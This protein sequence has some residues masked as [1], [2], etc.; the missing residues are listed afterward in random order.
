MKKSCILNLVVIIILCFTGTAFSDSWRNG[1][2]KRGHDKQQYSQRHQDRRDRSDR[3]DYREDTDR[4]ETYSRRDHGN[5]ADFH[6]YHGYR[7]L[8]YGKSRHY[9]HHD[10]RGHRYAYQGHW[11][12]WEQW[13]RYA[14]VH[15]EIY[16]HGDYYREGAHLMFRFLDPVSG[17]YFFFSIGR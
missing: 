16:R 11:K 2:G 17:G 12:S 13:D 7:E 6:K 4:R 1:S 3:R 14:K 15:P 10:H 9:K 5:R 8:P